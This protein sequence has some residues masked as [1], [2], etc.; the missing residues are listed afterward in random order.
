M[1]SCFFAHGIRYREGAFNSSATSSIGSLNFLA[2][3]FLVIPTVFAT[4]A[5]SEV[6]NYAGARIL[7][8]GIGLMLL[9]LYFL[10]VVFWVYSHAHLYD[11]D[12]LEGDNGDD[13]NKAVTMSLGP[14]AAFIWLTLSLTC[15]ALC[16]TVLISN[17]NGSIWKAN[18]MFL[19]FVLFPFL[20]NITDYVLACRVAWNDEMDITMLA[21]LGSSMQIMLFTLPF[22]VILGWIINEQLTLH[23]QTFELAAAFVGVFITNILIQSGKS[24]YFSGATSIALYVLP[25]Q[26]NPQARQ[27][28][29]QR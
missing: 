7:S 14:I 9:L 24:N 11:D 12:D 18:K 15:V 25:P 28:L 16:A 2:L 10:Y 19:S 3:S 26:A 17:I 22:L 1:G 4:V 13:S 6:N 23:F 8:H 29:L 21:T 20:G 27:R 5:S